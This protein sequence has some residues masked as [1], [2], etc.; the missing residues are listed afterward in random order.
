MND[1]IISTNNNQDTNQNEQNE[2]K[3]LE[4]EYVSSSDENP[5]Q[6]DKKKEYFV[7]DVEGVFYISFAGVD[8]VTKEALWIPVRVCSRLDIVAYIH[9]EK[10]GSC[11]RVLKIYN[12]ITSEAAEWVLP[13]EYLKN[14]GDELRG[15]LLYYGADI[16][17]SK[18][19]NKLL[20]R[21][22]KETET[23][24]RAIILERLGWYD[25]K[26]VLPDKIVAPKV[27]KSE[28]VYFNNDRD[29]INRFTQN[30]TLESWQENVSK[31]CIGNSRLVFAVCTAFAAPLVRLLK[32]K[33]VGFHLT[34]NSAIGKT[35]ALRV[36]ASVCGGKEYMH[37]WKGTDNGLEGVASYHNDTL[38]ALDE[39]S[40][41][42]EEVISKIIYMFAN[43]QGKVRATKSGLPRP[44]LNW[45][46]I[47]LSTGEIGTETLIGKYEE[48][49]K[50][51]LFAR[52][53]DLLADAGKDMGMFE[54]IH[55]AASAKEFS[56]LLQQ[57]SL[58]HHGMAFVKYIEHLVNSLS[59]DEEFIAYL[60]NT[61]KELEDKLLAKY[62]NSGGQVQRVSGSFALVAL[63]GLVATV[64][65]VTSWSENEAY[66]AT[67]KLFDAWVENREHLDNLEGSMAF[68][69][70]KYF[71]EQNVNSNKLTVLD[72]K[73]NI[74]DRTRSYQGQVGYLYNHDGRYEAFIP[75]ETYKKVIVPLSGLTRKTI[76]NM[77]LEKGWLKQG[78][79]DS[80]HNTFWPYTTIAL[81]QP[82]PS[83][84]DD[85][86]KLH[87]SSSKKIYSFQ[88]VYVFDLN[89]ILGDG[90]EAGAKIS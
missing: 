58:N 7:N 41:V 33:S 64:A 23:Q 39:I 50:A 6:K 10:G 63:G 34:G 86:A 54:N 62:P 8:E 42:K 16:P 1:E 22:I 17:E 84:E 40:E 88:K 80:E 19:V 72:R 5:N 61:Y 9:D 32:A 38:L 35:T 56:N 77:L 68:E 73:K 52:Q 24:G 89:K 66:E 29:K 12:N 30:G 13:M 70:I 44:T 74:E 36:A 65:G 11:G 53:I 51:G 37:Q 43:G 57:G 81:P 76:T 67:E 90:L 85:V 79:N 60:R 26:F 59:E 55:D 25:S 2:Q 47:W 71:W 75:T 15:A 69:Q 20:N 18:Q 28:L 46:L 27:S 45:E 31:L 87:G 4:G 14:G 83:L 21:Y 48:N 49:P 78:K 3:T 82:K